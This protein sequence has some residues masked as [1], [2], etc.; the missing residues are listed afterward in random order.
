MKR[1]RLASVLALLIWA[2]L[3]PPLLLAMW[4][5]YDTVVQRGIDL[6]QAGMG[7]AKNLAAAI[8]NRLE[9]RILA[10]RLLADSPLADDPGQWAALYEEARAFHANFGNHV[11]FADTERRMRFNTRVGFGPDL[12]R[13]P[14]SRGRSAAP[15]ALATGQPAVGDI[16]IGPVLNE[17]LV[18]IVVPGVRDGTV[19]HLML[20]TL[21]AREFQQR[22][23]ELALPEGWAISLADSS[24]ALVAQRGPPGFD[25]E[26]DVDAQWRF[27]VTLATAPWT[28]TVD[29]P[30][31]VASAPLGRFGL[32]LAGALALATLAG[33]LGGRFMAL[34]INREVK[35]LSADTPAPESSGIEEFA[36]AGQRLAASLGELR[37]SEA[38]HREMFE[39]HPQPMWVYDLETLHFLAVNEAAIRHY[40][41]SRDEFLA[42]TIKDIRPTEDVS[43]LLENVAQVSGGL[44][45]AGV[46]R[47][48]TKSGAVIEVEIS[49]HTLRFA[50]RDA[51]L[52]RINDVT[53]TRR[54]AREIEDYR[55]RLEDLVAARTAE[56]EDARE[57]AE[58]ASKAKSTFLANMSHE[59][60]TP[61][62]AILGLTYL[63]RRRAAP[64]QVEQLDKID[65]AGRHLLSIIS[66]V[67]DLS[68]IEAERV[69]LEAVDFR[70]VEVLE[71]VCNL[72]SEAAT[73]K[74]LTVETDT[75]GA[76]EWLRGD[77]TRLR[78]A[79]LN[80]AGNAVK[81]SARG[82]IALRVRTLEEAPGSLLL[83]FEVQDTGIG[84][85]PEELA[86]LFEPFEQ[87]DRATTRKFGGSGLGLIITRRLAELMGGEAGAASQPGAGSTF[88]F[89][90]RFERCK[91]GPEPV[92]AAPAQGAERKAPSV[93]ESL[94]TLHAG[95]QVLLV[96]DNPINCEVASI[97]LDNVGLEVHTAQD[98]LEAIDKARERP[99]DVVLMDV[100]MPRMDGLAATRTIRALPGWAGVP[101]IA[102]TASAFADDRANCLAAGMNDF[103]AKPVNPA[104]LY[105]TLLEWLSRSPRT[106][107]QSSAET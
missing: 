69:R 1:Q 6:R 33:L 39:V 61:L 91:T 50:G 65:G 59:I 11:I 41:Y 102:M 99:Y 101:I 55:H 84:I 21:T 30:R 90:A 18:A 5:S 49:S 98:G 95:R 82:C 15:I 54:I 94:R 78:Q 14:V 38:S 44:D 75:G 100:Q 32:A 57:Q 34:R 81:F 52:V 35:N 22:I 105:A 47:H 36:A 68:K 4:L 86:R 87:A 3:L 64:H 104:A 48:V 19:R 85:A 28:V 40:G 2:S 23:E 8:D 96:E 66:N 53:E 20:V 31:A 43:R 89:T 42:M 83:R 73:A 16:V 12:P 46:W 24:G 92:S 88:W 80:Y 60:R 56:L 62:N 45:L 93:E 26:R 7:Q 74:G 77:P 63:M 67:L 25:P 17:P 103:V 107:R 72:V 58:A 10:L 71:D 51:E 97:L 79:L 13:L 9:A 37:A 106:S 29:I 27:P 76:P 70:L